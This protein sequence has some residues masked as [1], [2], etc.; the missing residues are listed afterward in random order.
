M[1]ISEVAKSNRRRFLRLASALGIGLGFSLCRDSKRRSFVLSATV[2]FPDDVGFGLYTEKLLDEMMSQIKS[3]G[4]QRIYWL[5]YGDVDPQSYWAETMFGYMKYGA[6]MLEQI[7]EPVKAVTAIAHRH[8][9]D[10]YGV[11]KPFNT[12]M[13]G[14]YPEGSPEA[15][16]TSISRIGGTLQQAIP[17]IE[18]H[19]HTRV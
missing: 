9:L 13:A 17:F 8:G 14:T 19:P 6:K 16:T 15:E 18:Q 7:G 4:V 11:L 12:G 10:I 5:Y 2:D 3:M 1:S